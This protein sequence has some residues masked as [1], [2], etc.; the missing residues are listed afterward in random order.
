V[1]SGRPRDAAIPVALMVVA[2]LWRLLLL[3]RVY[4]NI[5][6]D[7]AVIGVMA[8]HI[9][10]GHHPLMYAGQ[11]YQGSL[12][13]YAAALLFVLC[14]ASDW[15]LRLPVL[16]CAV[17]FVGAVYALGA[18]LYGRRVAAVS[19][20]VVA[21]GPGALLYYG[22]VT[23]FGYIEVL[24]L[25][26]IL[27]ILQARHPDPRARPV[28]V[29]LA[30]GLVAGLGA[31]IEPLMAVYLLPLGVAE[32]WALL[33]VR[34][35]P[36]APLARARSLATTVLGL[37][38]GG[39]PLLAYNLHHRWATLSY[40]VASGGQRVDH[41]AAAVRLAT[42][43]LPVLL[44]LAV[45]T[46]NHG[47]FT[48]LV[49]RYPAQHVV[50]VVVGVYLLG[51]LVRALPRRIAALR[52]SRPRTGE[53]LAGQP[54]RPGQPHDGVLA[55]FIASCLLVVLGTH[56]VT[57]DSA[58]DTAR[59]LLPLYTATPLVVDLVWPRR[60]RRRATLRATLTLGTLLATNMALAVAIPQDLAPRGPVASL[61]RTLEARGARVVYTN[62]WLC[63]Q[64]T[65]ESR[66][67]VRGIPVNG[68][69]LARV[70]VLDDL[71]V[72]AR[73]PAARL[74][75]AFVA[76]APGE[77]RFQR[78]LRQTQTRAEQ[79]RWAN[80]VIYDHLSRPLRA[81]GPYEHAGAP[82]FEATQ[83]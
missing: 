9:Q 34:R 50:G 82:W 57:G 46:S 53:Q 29:A 63:Y 39:A 44:G 36:F 15:T 26:T 30:A 80:L 12:E 59:Y 66:G 38:I 20:A 58:I 13:A 16:V 75:W 19:A 43:S 17:L 23:G 81:H 41:L 5:D 32:A 65:F 47:V 2:A 33:T 6:S 35:G 42:E 55:L 45:P 22:D 72:A 67:R 18:T 7:Q 8:Y 10:A 4:T 21:L 62:Y 76:G 54:V 77:R 68:V 14:G 11:P 70:R 64:L 83:P 37:A 1:R 3:G 78:L 27:L 40:L 56:F 71:D 49:A 79:T 52:A 69:T 28:G 31:W 25:G 74:A 60:P 51:R 48:H 73:T 61:V 24:L